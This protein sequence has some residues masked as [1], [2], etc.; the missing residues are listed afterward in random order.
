MPTT[1]V[2]LLT[3]EEFA[4]LPDPNDGSKQELVHG[5][6]VTM[7]P[8]AIRHGM[9]QTNMAILLGM[10]V[11]P[12]GLGT[13]VTESGT[14]TDRDPDTVRGPDVSF[15]S[16]AGMPEIPNGYH[17]ARPELVVEILSPGDRRKTVRAKILEY[18]DAGVRL[19]WLVDPEARTVTVYHGTMR[20][21]ELGEGDRLDG[22]DALPGFTCAVADVF[23]R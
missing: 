16:L 13:V 18:L 5:E 23:K 2:K 22:V 8:P 12:N 10:F 17:H 14:V 3:A 6:I 21:V 19:V 1:A 7:P 15:Y 11:K 4:G 9:L 20:G